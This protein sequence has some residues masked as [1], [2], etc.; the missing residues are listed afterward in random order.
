MLQII[1]IHGPFLKR[2]SGKFKRD[3]ETPRLV[4]CKP[5]WIVRVLHGSVLR[6]YQLIGEYGDAFTILG[7]WSRAARK[8]GWPQEEIDHILAEA[9]L[10][11]Y[12]HLLGDDE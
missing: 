3:G 1:G 8:A 7:L 10:G 11:N 12:D 6:D 5:Y 9:R 4:K 2:P